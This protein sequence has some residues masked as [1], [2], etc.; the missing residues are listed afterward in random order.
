MAK[1][2]LGG[3]QLNYNKS[4]YTGSSGAVTYA[5]IKDGG[6]NTPTGG[7]V[8]SASRIYIPRQPKENSEAANKAYVDA[9][10]G[11]SDVSAGQI[12]FGDFSGTGLDGNAQFLVDNASADGGKAFDIVY[13]SKGVNAT[14]TGSFR[15]TAAR[16][17]VTGSGNVFMTTTGTAIVAPE[18]A[19]TLSSSAGATTVAATTSLVL[20]GASVNVDADNGALALDGSSGINIG[21]EAD[22]AIDIDSSTLDIDASGAITMDTS[23]GGISIDAAAGAVNLSS[24]ASTLSLSALGEIDLTTTGGAIDMNAGGALTVDVGLTGAAGISLD[25]TAASNFTN[26]AGNLTIHCNSGGT[27]LILSGANVDVD[28]DQGTLSLDGSA[29]I[30]IGTQT[31]VAIDIDADTLDIDADGAITIDGEG[32]SLDSSAAANL[33]ASGGALTLAG[34]TLDIDASAGAFAIDGTE[35]STVTVT[36]SG[37][38]LSLVAGGGGAQEIDLT[39]AGTSASAIDLNASAGGITLNTATSAKSIALTAAGGGA[40]EI[41]LTSAGTAAT[42]IDLNATAGG[43]TLDVSTSAKSIVLTAAGGGA[44]EIELSSAGTTA[45]AI[46]INATAGGV[47][48]DASGAVSLDGEDDSNFTVA[49]AGKVLTLEASG[50]SSQVVLLQ[51]AGTGANAIDINA[52]AGGITIDASDAGVSIDGIAASNFSTTGG[53]LTLSGSGGVTLGGSAT[54]SGGAGTALT[55]TDIMSFVEPSY[56]WFQD[57]VTPTYDA[58]GTPTSPNGTVAVFSA[59]LGITGSFVTGSEHVYLNGVRQ[60]E[61][62]SNDYGAAQITHRAGASQKNYLMISFATA[63]VTNDTIQI[64]FRRSI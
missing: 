13:D 37:Q 63:P 44:Q 31:D 29:G 24:A 34:V 35:A 40:Q 50:G 48:V 15:L 18:G 49:A 46:D 59:S 17:E 23:A 14:A 43:I 56:G 32:L 12:V 27:S 9:Q 7:L 36:G 30:N 60:V 47:A 25:S 5:V 62:A 3:I 51:S 42:A 16:F 54:F 52:T 11:G 45:S 1:T 21:T 39:S 33:T 2:K 41:D 8:L 61:G 53:A 6:S 10:T 57:G 64:D 55:L 26:T 28:A 58:W 4:A 20:S 22:V 19:L 38:S